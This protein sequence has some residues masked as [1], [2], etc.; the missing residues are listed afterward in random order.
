MVYPAVK[1]LIFFRCRHFS[2]TQHTTATATHKTLTGIP[3]NAQERPQPLTRHGQA[4]HTTYH[5]HS[6]SQGTVIR[7]AQG[8][9][10]QATS[11][12]HTTP[13]GEANKPPPLPPPP[14]PP[15]LLLLLLSVAVFEAGATMTGTKQRP[16]V[17]VLQ[18][19]GRG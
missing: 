15:P 17:Y 16:F 14:P 7:S 18:R 3:H 12:A 9:P 11:T 8:K 2:H 4:Y 5:G 1:R 13:F 19:K 10:V 6:Y